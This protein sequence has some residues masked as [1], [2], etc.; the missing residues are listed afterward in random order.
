[1]N[2][3]MIYHRN[4]DNSWIDQKYWIVKQFYYETP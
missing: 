1:M 4:N 2:D 3:K